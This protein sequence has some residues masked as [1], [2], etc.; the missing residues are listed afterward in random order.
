MDE[1]RKSKRGFASMSPEKRREIARKGGKS[2]PAGKRSF[3]QD[4]KLAAKAGKKGGQSVKPANRSF[5]RDHAL[6]SEAGHKGGTASHKKRQ[7]GEG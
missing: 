5:S 6:A 3:S 2:V 4:A 7:Q 1:P